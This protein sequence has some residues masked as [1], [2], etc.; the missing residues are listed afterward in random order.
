MTALRIACLLP[1]ATEICFELGLGAQVVGVS[2]ECDYPSAARDLPSLTRSSID[3]RASGR[4][5]DEAVRA[6]WAQGL[7]LYDVDEHRLAA[8]RPDLVITQNTCEVCA[9]SEQQVRQAARAGLGSHVQV[10]P[11]SPMNVADVFDDLRRVGIAAEVEAK[12]RAVVE[13]LELRLATLRGRTVDLSPRT[14][15]HLE[16]LEP[17]MVAGHWTPELLNAAGG[18]PVLAHPGRPTVGTTWDALC[19]VGVER[20][21]VA[22]CGYSVDKARQEYA[23]LREHPAVRGR[24]TS[25]LDGNAYFNRPGP[26]LVR[27][28]ELAAVALHPEVFGD[29]PEVHRLP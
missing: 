20:V 13:R 23:S 21:L 17:P 2:H 14:V 6:R 7:S 22:P 19:E 27:S 12:A 26:R 4:A 3:S 16:W 29:D 28:A 1:S 5:I 25:I 10:L 18:A 15:L 11:L 8:V 24:P 9:V